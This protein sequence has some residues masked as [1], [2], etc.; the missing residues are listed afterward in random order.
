M[1]RW[2]DIKNYE[3]LYQV[4]SY[5]RI[6]SFIKWNGH[7]YIQSVRILKPTLQNKNGNYRINTI[8]LIKNK[9]SNLNKEKF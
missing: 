6:K 2:K 4:S 1:E 8:C 9:R 5:G 3:G 7:K